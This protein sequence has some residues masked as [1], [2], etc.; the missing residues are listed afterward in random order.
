MQPGSQQFL[1]IAGIAADTLG[2]D[3]ARI[4]RAERI[5]GGL[6]NE[7]WLVSGAGECVV[8]RVST[9][10]EAALQIDRTSEGR[11]LPQVQSAG[12]GPEVLRWHPEGRLLVT[13]YI[14]GTVWTAEDARAPDSIRR[15]AVL[16]RQLHSLKVR[17]DI[18]VV[19]LPAIL[20]HYWA[21]L[22]ERG[23]PDPST[24]WTRAEMRAAAVELTV[25]PRCLCHNDAHHLNVIDTGRLW[26]ID[27]EY[28]GLGSPW[29]DLASV[30]CNHDYDGVQRRQLL[31][32]YLGEDGKGLLQL[33]LACR[34]F[35]DIRKLWLA[36]RAG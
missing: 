32:H 2:V 34:L 26:L 27:W 6:T 25:G 31:R 16:L 3:V 21:T 19:D 11:I 30:A 22:A 24:D 5:K 17:D 10:D 8:V 29:F 23:Q 13:R 35:D 14:P 15:L 4:E 7:S 28:A 1:R 36:V 33:E 18:A 9:A 12:I 20:D